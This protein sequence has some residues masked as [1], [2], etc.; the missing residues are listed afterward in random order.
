MYNLPKF[1]LSCDMRCLLVIHK[2]QLP[3]LYYVNFHYK[4]VFLNTWFHIHTIII[5]KLQNYF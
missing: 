1:S 2:Y 3:C 4:E 5:V